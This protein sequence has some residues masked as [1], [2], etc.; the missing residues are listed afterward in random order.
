MHKLEFEL[1][2]LAEKV[3]ELDEDLGRQLRHLAGKSHNY[4][5]SDSEE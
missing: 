1:A 3:R 2:Q 4:L 5:P